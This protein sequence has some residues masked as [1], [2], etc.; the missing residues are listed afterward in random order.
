MN[1]Q[2]V[3]DSEVMCV[4]KCVDECVSKH[5]VNIISI[6]QDECS[7]CLDE[8]ESGKNKLVT[9]CGHMFH[10]SCL[11]KNASINGFG[12]PMCR[13]VLADEE[14]EDAEEDD[15]EEE[16]E[17]YTEHSLRGMRWLFQQAQ[18]EEIVEEDEDMD[19]YDGDS[20]DDSIYNVP[21]IDHVMQQLQNHNVSMVDVVKT[22]MSSNYGGY[23]DM[24]MASE[25]MF[26][27]FDRI[28]VDN[29]TIPNVPA[30]VMQEHD[31]V[32]QQLQQ[33]LQLQLPSVE[34]HQDVDI[35]ITPLTPPSVIQPDLEVDMIVTDSIAQNDTSYNASFYSHR[36]SSQQWFPR[37]EIYLR[38]C[39]DFFGRSR[40]ESTSIKP[41]IQLQSVKSEIQ[42]QSVKSEIQLQSVKSEIQVKSEIHV[43][44]R[45]SSLNHGEVSN[46]W[47]L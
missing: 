9:E 15:D 39:K 4:D 23:N 36:Y 27:L 25:E 35:S 22:L 33:S 29:E 20:E 19:E 40:T 41:E 10:T 30:V 38:K 44:K 14:E 32:V 42:L 7:I 13:A 17:L 37:V 18:G 8:I 1:L 28:I 5:C 47:Y 16:E 34:L 21:T 11:L 31:I 45:N 12:C 3:F 26:A 46:C 2:S 43:H 6:S 24:D